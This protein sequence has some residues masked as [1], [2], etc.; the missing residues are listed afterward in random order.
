L[1]ENFGVEKIKIPLYAEI[2]M[3]NAQNTNPEIKKAA[4][5]Y[6]KAVYKWIGDVI[7]P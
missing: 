7:K 5:N 3:K 6:Y 2:M 4:Y 1:V